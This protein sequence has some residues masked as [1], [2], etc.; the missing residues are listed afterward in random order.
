MVYAQ[1]HEQNIW[2]SCIPLEL[3]EKDAQGKVIK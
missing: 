3:K 1:I 2:I